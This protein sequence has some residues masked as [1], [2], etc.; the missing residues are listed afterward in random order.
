MPPNRVPL[1]FPQGLQGEP[2]AFTDAHSFATAY[3]EADAIRGW[4]G[5]LGTIDDIYVFCDSSRHG[6]EKCLADW[7]S[8]D[9][10]RAKFRGSSQAKLRA[11]LG[12][13]VACTL[14][15]LVHA[16]GP[17]DL[18]ARHLLYYP[19]LDK[20]GTEIPAT[21]SRVIPFAPLIA[22]STSGVSSATVFSLQGPGDTAEV[23]MIRKLGILLYEIGSWSVVPEQGSGLPG[24]VRYARVEK[25]RLANISPVYRDVVRSCLDYGEESDVGTW[26][27]ENVVEPMKGMVQRLDNIELLQ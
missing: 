18:E 23:R 1:P 4:A 9:G 2:T 8:D 6:P 13:T 24:K 16:L 15:H 14:F 7:L 10:E 22:K 21:G 25:E 26:M 17:K 5:F 3:P 11:R 12:S 20:D 27:F 19:P